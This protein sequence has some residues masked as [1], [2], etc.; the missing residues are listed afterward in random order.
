MAD[1]A[2][3]PDVMMY[4]SILIIVYKLLVESEKAGNSALGNVTGIAKMRR[5]SAIYQHHPH[6]V[7]RGRGPRSGIRSVMRPRARPSYCRPRDKL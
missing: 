1:D 5:R 7:S 4:L 2:P 6:H 3:G